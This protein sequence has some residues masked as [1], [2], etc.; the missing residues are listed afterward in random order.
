MDI[1]GQ[2]GKQS[3]FSLSLIQLFI[4]AI[5]IN[6]RLDLFHQSIIVVLV[7]N[8]SKHRISDNITVSVNEYGCRK[9][10]NIGSIFPCIGRCVDG[11]IAVFGPLAFKNCCGFFDRSFVSVEGCLL[12][13]S[14]RCRRRLRCRSRWSPYH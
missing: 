10:H 4:C 5:C 11:E 2:A 13:T 9:C 7:I 6:Y 3:S 14:G 8:S 12:Y 1:Q